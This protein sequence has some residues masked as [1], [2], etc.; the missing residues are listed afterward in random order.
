MRKTVG[1]AIN[2]ARGE[3]KDV[4]EGSFTYSHEDMARYCGE[5]VVEMRRVRP[6]TRYDANM[7]LYS[8]DDEWA[9]LGPGASGETLPLESRYYAAIP[10][11]IIARCLS[12]DIT[13]ETNLQVASIWMG[14]FSQIAAG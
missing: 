10:A 1:D 11:F 9:T 12:R 14:K 4:N 7:N 2:E 3:L 6:S 13:D 5:A 8:D